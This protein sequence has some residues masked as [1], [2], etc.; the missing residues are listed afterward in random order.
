M[1]ASKITLMED[2]TI[3]CVKGGKLRAMYDCNKITKT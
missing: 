2:K 3:P 1:T